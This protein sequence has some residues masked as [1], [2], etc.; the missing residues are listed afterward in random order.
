MGS[1]YSVTPLVPV[2]A[3]VTKDVVVLP[4]LVVIVENVVAVE[5][6]VVC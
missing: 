6:W 2:V 5:L 3:V 1:V 4:P